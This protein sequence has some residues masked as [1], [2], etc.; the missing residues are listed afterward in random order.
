MAKRTE[1]VVDYA[2][3]A[4]RLLEKNEELA[5][6][7]VQEIEDNPGGVFPAGVQEDHASS[8]G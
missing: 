4:K 5:A 8:S 3:I 7:M 2:K 1:K 6:P